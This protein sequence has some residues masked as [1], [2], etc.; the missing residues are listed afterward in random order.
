MIEIERDR[1]RDRDTLAFT[2]TDMGGG[3][4]RKKQQM[5]NK[6]ANN[7]PTKREKGAYVSR[8]GNGRFTTGQ[9]TSTSKASLKCPLRTGKG[10][11]CTNIINGRNKQQHSIRSFV[12][13]AIHEPAGVNLDANS[14]ACLEC[15]SILRAAKTAHCKQFTPMT[16]SV[17]IYKLDDEASVV[18]VY[19]SPFTSHPFTSL[20]P[21]SP[22][23]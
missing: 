9:E 12:T 20:L 6:K 7:I 22:A 10:T 13:F 21:S 3:A 5:L 1:D 19:C 8:A 14:Y 18:V 23:P 17:S 2:P 15:L 16:S 4:K 11:R